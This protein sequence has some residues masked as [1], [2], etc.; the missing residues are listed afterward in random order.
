MG[1]LLDAVQGQGSS[2]PVSLGVVRYFGDYELVEEIAR[3]G[4]GVVYKARQ[5]SL[6][7]I[8]AVKMILA[9]QLASEA[10]VRRFRSEAEAAAQLQHSNIVAIHEVGEYDGRNYFSMD[11]VEGTSLAVVV[12]E[13]PPQPRQA[14]AIVRVI[15]ETI[16]YAHRRGILHRDLKPSNVLID[17]T[18]QPRVTD[19]GL[20]KRIEGGSELT[21]TGA[22]LGTPS[23]MP[24][25]QASGERGR[26][27]PASDVYALGAILYELFTGRPPFR[28]DS[29]LDTLLQVLQADPVGPRLLNPNLPRELETITLKCLQKE[30]NGRYRTAQDL[31]DDLGRYLRGEPV[32][33][34]PVDSITR[35]WKWCRRN[36]AVASLSAASVVLLAAVA[37]TASIGYFTSRG[38]EAIANKAAS[39][40]LAAKDKTRREA[41]HTRRLLYDADMQLAAQVWESDSGTAQAVSDLLRAHIPKGEDSDLRE[42][43]WYYQS[44]QLND[45]ASTLS[46]H[47]GPIMG[48]AFDRDRTLIT[49]DVRKTLRRWDPFE[50]RLLASATTEVANRQW[51]CSIARDGRLLALGSE[52]TIRLIDTRSTSVEG[53]LQCAAHVRD[54]ELSPDGQML[55]AMCVDRTIQ[56]WNTA[57]RKPTVTFEL[58]PHGEY[59]AMAVAPDGKSVLLAGHPFHDHATLYSESQPRGQR[60]PGTGSTVVSAAFSADGKLA[61]AGD[62]GG[63]AHVW[64][65]SGRSVGS[66][67]RASLKWAT[68]LAFAPNGRDLAVG[69][70]EGRVSVW[71]IASRK[72]LVNLKSHR[73]QV[74]MLAFSQDGRWLASGS[75]DGVSRVWQVT[76][77]KP[78][79]ELPT[80]VK[81]GAVTGLAFSPDGRWLAEASGATRLRDAASGTT[82]R[83][84]YGPR[85]IAVAFSPDSARIATACDDSNVRVWNVATGA[86][87]RV[88]PGHPPNDSY[89]HRVA[90]SVAFS[91]D[92]RLLAAGFGSHNMGIGDY[93]QIVQVW[94]AA[95]GNE[96]RTITGFQNTVAS[97]AFSPD[98]AV[99]ATACHDRHVRLW[100]VPDWRMMNGFVGR[101]RFTCVSFSPQRGLLA[102]ANDDGSVYVWDYAASRELYNLTGHAN[103]AKG[104]WFSPNSRTLAS[105]SWDGTVK[106]W[107]ILT[108]REI[109]TLMGEPEW[110]HSIAFSPDGS[111]LAS[112]RW[113]GMIRAWESVDAE[114]RSRIVAAAFDT[115]VA[116]RP[117]DPRAWLDRGWFLVRQ[118]S[119]ELAR[120]DFSEAARLASDQ[121]EIWLDIAR[122][123][124]Q[125]G[126]NA[127]ADTAYAHFAEQA[128]DEVDRFLQGW[129]TVGPFA[130]EFET[131]FPPERDPDPS[132]LVATVDSNGD[133]RQ[134]QWH[135]I[136]AESSGLLHLDEVSGRGPATAYALSHVF[137]KQ[138]RPVEFHIK[139]AGN[140]CLWLNGKVIHRAASGDVQHTAV[141]PVVLHAG[142]NTLLAKVTND[143]SSEFR[144]EIHTA[145]IPSHRVERA[146]SQRRWADAATAM[147][148]LSAQNCDD[149]FTARHWAYLRL[150][151]GDIEGYRRVCQRL[152]E[153][154]GDTS[155]PDFAANTALACVQHGDDATNWNAVAQ[156]AERATRGNPTIGWYWHTLGVSYFRQGRF[157]QALQALDQSDQ[158][159][160]G[161]PGRILND[162]VRS[163]TLHQMGRAAEARQ[164]FQRVSEW[165]AQYSND[166]DD[167]PLNA[168]N[169]WWDAVSFHN[170][171]REARE[172]LERP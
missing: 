85:A 166:P 27:G 22:I 154:F 130:A 102:A 29:P 73:G 69:G 30:P 8:V 125:C 12:R 126:D 158:K 14:V 131:A 171:A 107:D 113:D 31:A 88:L 90:N 70:T 1:R 135:S 78:F 58:Q 119:C 99:L 137:A 122:G 24:P 152:L 114:E 77:R 47:A 156:L 160:P 129:W 146:L 120:S 141:A 39:N 38:A 2:P 134:L 143:G 100:E 106:L 7:R 105:A 91:P 163:M 44:T 145:E 110:V 136:Q 162:V 153:R 124:A 83:T 62:G 56:I 112:G 46:E 149:T 132:H 86:L 20:A 63:W 53:I 6:N 95:T 51:C 67:M 64:D 61:A 13:N 117:R 116:Q 72:R 144:V 89:D 92:G 11:Y 25:E 139:P 55:A 4:M 170:L 35:L 115:I 26:V 155:A 111:A 104:L 147:E 76:E 3:G 19:F 50:R 23:Y 71:D 17:A 159:D 42:F 133:Q 49:F 52:N 79:R 140:V 66:P 15:A 121:P 148:R 109:R 87:L 118:Q 41:E 65:A 97:V 167:V 48:L 54:V 40:A 168:L 80:L 94:N 21:A 101:D 84:L 81:H 142:R 172:T 37:V 103:H 45:N 32:H 96:I 16:E 123:S 161:W 108:G 36:P 164:V 34:Q 10:D 5:L 150:R 60:L 151:A 57:T 74:T 128:S 93:D 98:G 43:A 165:Q 18:G 157:E 9:G 33:A 59:R 82:I 68:A 28:A 138:E 127:D 75:E 169:V